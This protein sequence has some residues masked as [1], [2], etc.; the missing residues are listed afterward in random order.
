[1]A[2]IKKVKKYQTSGPPL[3]VNRVGKFKKQTFE[4]DTSGYAAGKKSFPTKITTTRINK[5]GEE[6][7]MKNSIYMRNVRRGAVEEELGQREKMKKQMEGKMKM[8]GKMKK[9]A[10]GVT[11]GPGPKKTV[12]Q[13]LKM[14]YPDVDTTAKGDVRG[15]EMNASAPKKV[16]KKYNDTYNAFEKKFGN[17]PAKD[18][19]GGVV[20]SKMKMGGKMSKK[21]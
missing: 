17:K 5:K 4:T 9:A 14:K 18:K 15:S 13:K 7:P 10:M 20:K 16:L 12:M 6:E 11:E 21:K 19:K 2:K 1:M 3:T 8:G